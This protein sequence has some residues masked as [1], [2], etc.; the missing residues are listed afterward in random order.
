VLQRSAEAR[1]V[2]FPDLL[3]LLQ[4]HLRSIDQCS[5]STDKM[6]EIYLCIAILC[7]L[8]KIMEQPNTVRW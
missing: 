4:V 3:N 1:E 5:D 7:R 2:V 6:D 8:F